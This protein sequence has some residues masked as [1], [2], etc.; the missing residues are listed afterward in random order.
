MVL[1][2]VKKL[3]DILRQKNY[4]T[5]NIFSQNL[6]TST[7]GN[8]IIKSCQV[9]LAS[10]RHFR[11]FFMK[12]D[13]ILEMSRKENAGKHDEREM[14]A[15]GTASRVG[16][17]VGGILCA[18]LVFLSEFLFK[19]HEIGLVAWLV[20]F[21]MQ[22]SHHITLYTKLKTNKHLVYGIVALAFTIAFAV[23]LCVVTLG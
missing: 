10:F 23:T 14:A 9:H 8:G 2:I 11:R 6:L 3:I 18:V 4:F 13:E 20:Y 5:F 7:L 21:A 1:I 12:K 15:F 17:L 22:G 16:M 19:V